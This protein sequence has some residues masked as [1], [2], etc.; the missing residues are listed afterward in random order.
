M[1]FNE[2]KSVKTKN[3]KRVGRG[4]SA[5]GGKTAGRGTKGQSARSGGKR[6]AGFEGGQNPLIARLPKLPGFKSHK[7]KK[8]EISLTQL[9]SVKGKVVDNNVLAEAGIVD[10]PYKA[11]KVIVKGE[12]KSAKTVKLQGA[13][14]GAVELIS[15]AGGSFE[16]TSLPYKRK[17]DRHD[18]KTG[19]SKKSA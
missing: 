18:A 5:G 15:K 14:A 7:T 1:K 11:T 16:Q 10:S 12:L 9:E 13:S 6:K 19:K 4:I 3:K 2:L 17:P 8:I